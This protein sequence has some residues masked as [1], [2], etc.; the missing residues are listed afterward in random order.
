[1]NAQ[2]KR[3][4]KSIEKLN[5]EIDVIDKAHV[6]ASATGSFKAQRLLARAR[7]HI[8]DALLLVRE[9]QKT[10]SADEEDDESDE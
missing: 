5:H 1:M 2:F 4:K 9:A 7:E 8:E 10:L 6:I 3:V